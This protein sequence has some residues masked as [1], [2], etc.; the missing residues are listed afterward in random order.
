MKNSDRCNKIRAKY[1]N[2]AVS[3]VEIVPSNPSSKKKKSK[4]KFN[5]IIHNNVFDQNFN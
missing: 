1:W 5:D 3:F 4:L 2:Y